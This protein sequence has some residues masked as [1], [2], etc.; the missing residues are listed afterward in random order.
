MVRLGP[1]MNKKFCGSSEKRID[2]GLLGRMR[3]FRRQKWERAKAQRPQVSRGVVTTL[4][5]LE[6]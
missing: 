1:S 4:G 2:M 5:H 3:V 6:W